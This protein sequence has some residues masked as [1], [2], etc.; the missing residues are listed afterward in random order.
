M[1]TVETLETNTLNLIHPEGILIEFKI[2]IL[3][4]Q[5]ILCC[6]LLSLEKEF[7]NK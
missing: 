7:Q 4:I 5:C 2:F 1:Y 3:V 6:I